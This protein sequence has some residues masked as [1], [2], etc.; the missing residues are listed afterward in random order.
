MSTETTVR[1]CGT[2]LRRLGVPNLA[3]AAGGNTGD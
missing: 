1:A 3:L 2:K